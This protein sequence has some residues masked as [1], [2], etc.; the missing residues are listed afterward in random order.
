AVV[1]ESIQLRFFNPN[2]TISAD[3]LRDL[4]ANANL[5]SLGYR[6]ITERKTETDFE[7]GF[8]VFQ[9][10]VRFLK[11]MPCGEV[12]NSEKMLD[13]LFPGAFGKDVTNKMRFE[14]QERKISKFKICLAGIE[15]HFK[16]CKFGRRLR[17]G[18]RGP[19]RYCD[20]CG[21]CDIAIVKD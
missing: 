7:T 16:K 20:G 3:D 19:K 1:D 6:K 2:F 21:V 9:E 5:P 8:P 15:F 17:R 10:T 18:A 12:P 14:F 13:Q 4:I 11:E